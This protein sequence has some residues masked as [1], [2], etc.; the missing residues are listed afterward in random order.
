VFLESVF[1]SEFMFLI[2]SF[3]SFSTS[4]NRNIHL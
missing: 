2:L 4:V 1:S 3:I